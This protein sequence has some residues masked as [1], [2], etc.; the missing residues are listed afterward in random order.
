LGVENR[1]LDIL[2]IQLPIGTDGLLV[3]SFR[4]GAVETGSPGR[5]PGRAHQQRNKTREAKSGPDHG[6]IL[7]NLT[8]EQTLPSG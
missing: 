5:L 8:A 4:F 6:I 3:S 7:E 2:V 1:H